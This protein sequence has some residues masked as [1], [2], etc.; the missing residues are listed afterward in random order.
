MKS[1][2]F[3]TGDSITDY[4]RVITLVFEWALQEHGKNATRI[5]FKKQD[6]VDAAAD[7]EIV[8]N[9]VPDVA[10]TYRSGRSSLPD[11]ILAHGQ[12]AIVGTG[13]G[14]YEFVRLARSPYVEI[15]G[16]LEIIRI[17][18]AT[19]QI[20][21][22]YQGSDEQALLARIRYNRLVDIFT[23]L[24]TYHLQSH[25]RSTVKGLG[26]VEID[27]LYIGVN[28]EGQGFMLPL[29]AKSADPRDRLG[30]I[31]ITQMVK[32]VKQ[33]FEDL[34]VRPLGVKVLPDQTYLFMEFTDSEDVTEVATRRFMRY[35]L[36]REA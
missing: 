32:F 35:E 4:D 29:E 7:L 22:K 18:D 5:P 6:I 8:I 21:L 25:F 1:K 31:Q 28:S 26:Q 17:L 20:V 33:H 3:E 34:P 9:N 13:K 16:D 30:V 11:A 36:Y 10:Y 15:P 14:Q 2:S 12:W 27:D 24:T 23:G 19:P